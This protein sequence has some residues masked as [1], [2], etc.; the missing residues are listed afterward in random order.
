MSDMG[1]QRVLPAGLPTELD[2]RGAEDRS[3]NH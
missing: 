3:L 1:S 2:Q